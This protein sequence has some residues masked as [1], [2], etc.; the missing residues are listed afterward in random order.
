V[1]LALH[2]GAAGLAQKL[3]KI[4]LNENKWVRGRALFFISHKDSF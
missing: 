1:S 4:L 3:G 2:P